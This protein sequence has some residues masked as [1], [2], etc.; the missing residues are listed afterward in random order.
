M[1][2]GFGAVDADVF[3]LFPFLCGRFWVAMC[4]SDT[5]ST[6]TSSDPDELVEHNVW[7]PMLGLFCHADVGI[8]M[9]A[10]ADEKVLGRIALSCHSAVDILC[11][12]SGTRCAQ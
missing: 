3:L 2:L 11:D 7:N 1:T 8:F 6:L 12:K 4:V 5:S 10:S 9:E